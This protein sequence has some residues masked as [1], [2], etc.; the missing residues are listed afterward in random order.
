MRRLRLA[1]LLLKYSAN[2]TES[3][4]LDIHQLRR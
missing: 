1:T 2:F 3:A 4:L